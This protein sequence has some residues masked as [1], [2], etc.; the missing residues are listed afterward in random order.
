MR[1]KECVNDQDFGA[2]R[3]QERAACEG[4]QH[5]IAPRP[6]SS[7]ASARNDANFVEGNHEL[8]EAY[9]V[10]ALPAYAYYRW[11]AF[12]SLAAKP[13]NGPK[14]ND[15]WQAPKSAAAWRPLRGGS[16]CATM[17]PVLGLSLALGGAMERVTGNVLHGRH[18]SQTS[19]SGVVNARR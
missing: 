1:G 9:A 2:T 18:A 11:R 19:Y 8:A 14:D 10:H 13:F 12:R 7:R 15:P 3:L 16:K 17:R 4:T 5:I 6:G